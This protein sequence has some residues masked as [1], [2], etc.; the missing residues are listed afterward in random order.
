[1]MVHDTV[2]CRWLAGWLQCRVFVAFVMCMCCRLGTTLQGPIHMQTT[3]PRHDMAD[4]KDSHALGKTMQASHPS[5]IESTRERRHPRARLP[6]NHP[7]ASVQCHWY[8]SINDKRLFPTPSHPLVRQSALQGFSLRSAASASHM[9]GHARGAPVCLS[10]ALS[11]NSV[12]PVVS[13]PL[14]SRLSFPPLCL[15][16]QTDGRRRRRPHARGSH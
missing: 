8:V 1:M 16:K 6:P 15:R 10:L 4:E 5:S 13:F 7:N 14:V 11:R 9:F 2:V 12:L 3:T